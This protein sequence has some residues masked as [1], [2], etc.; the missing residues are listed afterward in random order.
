MSTTK[1]NFQIDY[2]LTR[3]ILCG[4]APLEFLSASV[5]FLLVCL[6]KPSLIATVL[7]LAFRQN[8]HWYE[9]FQKVISQKT[10]GICKLY[11]RHLK[12][13]SNRGFNS[14]HK[15][16]NSNDSQYKYN[17]SH[18]SKMET[19]TMIAFCVLCFR[20]QNGDWAQ[21]TILLACDSFHK[22][23]YHRC[24]KISMKIYK[25]VKRVCRLELKRDHEP[26][27]FLQWSM[28]LFWR[29]SFLIQI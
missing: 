11:L 13:N 16:R 21:E 24:R 4:V 1:Y 14:W 19:E 7:F 26:Q 28:V 12:K 18:E 25:I 8:V 15:W 6:Q 23:C 20:P 9:V 2:T 5:P 27:W 3:F 22:I 29:K 17:C 10:N